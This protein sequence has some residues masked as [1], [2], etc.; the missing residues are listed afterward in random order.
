MKESENTFAYIESERYSVMHC[1]TSRSTEFYMAFCGVERCAPGHAY[2]KAPVAREHYHLH[3]I[4]AGKGVMKVGGMTF[5][6]H[7]N[8]A[9]LLKPGDKIF[10]QADMEHPWEYCWIT[11][12]G[13]LA[14]EYLEE[15][16]FA[17]GVY[18]RDLFGDPQEFSLLVRKLLSLSEI[19]L[20][21]DIRRT[22]IAM[23]YLALLMDSTLSEEQQVSRRR[24]DYS[25][26][27]YVSHAVNFIQ[28][29]YAK[30]RVNDIAKYIGINRSYLTKIFTRKIG[31]SPQEY[32]MEY[33]MNRGKELLTCTELSVQ[34]IAQRVGY[35]NPL[36][37]SK[38]FKRTCGLSPRHYRQRETGRP[39]ES[40]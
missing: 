9:F 5:H 7:K 3:V 29:N 30:I 2:S 33:R 26:D 20:A 35:E 31:V 24:Y 25:P 10:Y 18:T 28:L 36:T 11:I 38:M 19:T 1:N 14:K 17:D 4:L 37:F 40:Q 27:V 23:E 12:D 15:C 32:L 16:G 21:N 8:Q 13:S 39:K 34:E 22:A 6:L